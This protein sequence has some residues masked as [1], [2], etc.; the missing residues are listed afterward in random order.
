MCVP[1]PEQESTLQDG[2]GH[3]P[4]YNLRTLCRALEYAAS[5]A[6]VY[7]IQ[8]ALWDGFAMSFLT[9]L[10]PSCAPRL[11]QL[12]QRHLLGPGVSMAA[13]LRAP[14]QVHARLQFTCAQGGRDFP[15]FSRPPHAPLLRA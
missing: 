14:P 3:K 15:P 8:R 11:E 7:G 10:D 4:A 13:L 5:A 12:M 9:Q 1:C 6:P 2:A